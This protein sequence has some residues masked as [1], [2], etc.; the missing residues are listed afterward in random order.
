[1][2]TKLMTKYKVEARFEFTGHFIIETF[3]REEATR[4]FEQDCGCVL[5]EISTSQGDAVDWKFDVHPEKHWTDITKT[6][7]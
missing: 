5:G 4:I 6:G 1:M 3:S 2:E 7:D